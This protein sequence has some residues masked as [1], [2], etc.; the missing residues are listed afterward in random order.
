MEHLRGSVL[1]G[2]TGDVFSI[3]KTTATLTQFTEAANGS[4]QQF[5]GGLDG[6]TNVFSPMF[7]GGFGQSPAMYAF[8][9][10]PGMPPLN[11]MLPGASGPPTTGPAA[12]VVGGGGGGGPTD[13]DYRPPWPQNNVFLAEIQGWE[14]AVAPPALDTDPDPLRWIWKYKWK[15]V[16]RN[17]IW[18]DVYSQRSW[19]NNPGMIGESNTLTEVYAYNG[20]EYANWAER[21]QDP[22]SEDRRP[23]IGPF[24]INL[25]DASDQYLPFPLNYTDTTQGWQ[26]WEMFTDFLDDAPP[27]DLPTDNSLP[28]WDE[29]QQPAVKVGQPLPIG[30]HKRDVYYGSIVVGDSGLDTLEFSAAP[31]V[32]VLM[33]E[34]WVKKGDLSQGVDAPG[35]CPDCSAGGTGTGDNVV[36]FGGE[37]YVCSYWFYATNS[38]FD[39]PWVRGT[40]SPAQLGQTLQTL[41]DS[42][43]PGIPN[44]GW[45]AAT[46][47]P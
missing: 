44:Y 25:E 33:M 35:W 1:R 32:H 36:V 22:A 23:F 37:E 2:L 21:T 19:T 39:L 28:M 45:A 34:R 18:P 4:P 38:R 31:N 27:A 46:N 41:V 47:S 14:R 5:F 40:S 17:Y 6:G 3:P 7:F 43:L 12:V 24:A 29:N 30:H 42:T 8:P 16:G 15:E 20:C 9:N 10:M 11:M 26:D 13:P